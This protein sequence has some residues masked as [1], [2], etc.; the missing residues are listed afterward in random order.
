MYIVLF[1]KR[2]AGEALSP[3]GEYRQHGRRGPSRSRIRLRFR[4]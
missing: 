1:S 3:S 4:S 2:E